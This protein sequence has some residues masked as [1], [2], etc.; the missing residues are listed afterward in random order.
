M[1]IVM[2]GPAEAAHFAT[3]IEVA[4]GQVESPSGDQV[5]IVGIAFSLRDSETHDHVLMPVDIAWQ[6]VGSIL[7]GLASSRDQK[8]SQRAME[9]RLRM[10]E[11]E[12]T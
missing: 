2:L 3:G 7:E 12:R 10:K 8:L 4:I 1:R 9:A 6:A 5:E 11:L